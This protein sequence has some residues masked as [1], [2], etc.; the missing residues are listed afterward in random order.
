[1]DFGELIRSGA[2]QET[3]EQDGLKLLRYY[4]VDFELVMKVKGRNLEIKG[5][6]GGESFGGQQVSIAAAFVPGTK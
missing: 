1:M 3:I 2:I 4:R 5:C 6:I